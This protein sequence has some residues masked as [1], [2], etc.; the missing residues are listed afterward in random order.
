M[1]VSAHAS[2]LVSA[3]TIVVSEPISQNA[4]LS[5]SDVSIAAPV[6]GD[7]SVA[8]GTVAVSSP[9]GGDVLFAGGTV[10]VRKPVA[11]DVRGV[12]GE[13][14]VDSDIGGEL[15][16]AAGTLTASSTAKEMRLAG[17]TIRVL[18]SGGDVYAYGADI[19]LSGTIH[20]NVTVTASD[21][22]VVAEGTHIEGSLKYDAPQE[23]VV[24]ASAT[25]TGGT[26]YTGS[27]AFLPTNE[28]AKRFAVAGAGVL[29]VVRI[30]AILIAAGVVVGLFP[31][32]AEMI[33]SRSIARTPRRF[34]LLALLGF[35]AVVATP[36]LI[37]FL[38]ISFV[39]MALAVLLIALYV[40]LLILSYLYAGLLAGAALSRAL[41]K[42]DR[43]TWRTAVLGSLVLSIVGS[44]P[45]V[46][47][48]VVAI[49]TMVAFG[50][51][52]AIA[53]RTCFTHANENEQALVIEEVSE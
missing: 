43:I 4:Y 21:K 28:E 45:V 30:L 16:V 40:I 27:S 3:R 22:L 10:D 13:F 9:V 19:Y 18:G 33:V 8:G 34:I 2:T 14:L 52:M 15:A 26:S 44:V 49:L 29:L 5:G 12:A 51:L 38:L 7:V 20:G 47:P 46:G 41:F 1:P 32:L 48:L 24:P 11:G 39:G 50:V 36:V 53:Y 17:G 35:A 42:K 37:A 25:V 31:Q 6:V 23:V